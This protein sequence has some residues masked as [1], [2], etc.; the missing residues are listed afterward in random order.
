MTTL[1]IGSFLGLSF[2]I[3]DHFL[4]GDFSTNIYI[5]FGEFIKQE[6]IV[7]SIIFIIISII[8][9]ILWSLRKKVFKQFHDMADLIIEQSRI[10]KKD[11]KK[12]FQS[13]RARYLKI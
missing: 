1:L 3:F 9:I 12:Y 11:L 2:R 7:Y 6:V 4:E 10:N 8:F 5:A 13:E